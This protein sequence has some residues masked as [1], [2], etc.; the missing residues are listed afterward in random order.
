MNSQEELVGCLLQLIDAL[1][2]LPL[3]LPYA[4]KPN[5][6]GAREQQLGR[7]QVGIALERDGFRFGHIRHL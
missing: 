6:P 1:A 3:I 5:A 4:D 7:N 2:R